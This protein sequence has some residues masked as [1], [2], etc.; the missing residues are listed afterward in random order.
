[1]HYL[2]LALAIVAEVTGTS[3][4]KASAGFTRLGPTMVVLGAY[5][6][7]FFLLSLAV[8]RFPIG[9]LYAVWSG[10]GI[11]LIAIVGVIAYGERLDAAAVAGLF[12]IVGGVA[13]LHLFSETVSH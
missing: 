1:M 4:L 10:L 5:A 12:L 7:S 13:V 8:Q 11:V 6:L 9:V 2:Y 3:A